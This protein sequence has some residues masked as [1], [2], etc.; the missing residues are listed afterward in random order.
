LIGRI[1]VAA[2]LALIPTAMSAASPQATHAQAGPS[3]RVEP[4]SQQVQIG[5]TFQVTIRESG[6]F[7]AFGARTDLV[8]DP[9]VVQVVG[10]Q[11]GPEFANAAVTIGASG[12]SVDAAIAEANVSG[13]L[14]RIDVS[15]GS[16]SAP[17]GDHALVTLTMRALA[18]GTSALALSGDV[19]I[20]DGDGSCYGCGSG[21]DPGAS[22]GGV[23]VSAGI[24]VVSI[25]PV[26]TPVAST[27]VNTATAP[28]TGDAAGSSGSTPIW[29]WI[30]V[31]AGAAVAAVAFL[32]RR[33]RAAPP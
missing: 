24:V 19:E 30:V 28:P 29:P 10:V 11:P 7:A 27:A 25:G 16:G 14:T 4:A 20:I 32:I 1:V 6:P 8:F 18:N 5:K 26:A 17:A 23:T 9:S 12:Q 13:T 21:Q 2:C 33:R 15:L 22:R 31:G 3:L